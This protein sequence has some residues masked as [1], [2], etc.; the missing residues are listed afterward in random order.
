MTIP[1]GSHSAPLSGAGLLDDPDHCRA[2]ERLRERRRRLG[3]RLY[4]SRHLSRT[5]L[6]T[7]RVQE[8]ADTVVYLTLHRRALVRQ[9]P[10]G[11]P[12]AVERLTRLIRDGERIGWLCA[13]LVEPSPSPVDFGEVLAARHAYGERHYGD[14][15]VSRDNLAEALEEI[16]D[17]DLLG[18]LERERRAHLGVGEHPQAATLSLISDRCASLGEAVLALRARLGEDALRT[19]D[20]RRPRPPLSLADR[21]IGYLR[22]TRRHQQPAQP[23]ADRQAAA[24]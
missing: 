21:A 6:A 12:A 5:D 8:A 10:P 1:E 24:G 20:R 19:S 22:A 7:N 23:P 3:E 4:G 17:C 14:Q 11:A 9:G 18:D 16:A 15:Y 13:E 2:Y